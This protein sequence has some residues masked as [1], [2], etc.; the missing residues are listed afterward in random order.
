M[1]HDVRSE[2][3]KKADKITP[4]EAENTRQNTSSI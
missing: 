4:I 1:L 3:L 2:S